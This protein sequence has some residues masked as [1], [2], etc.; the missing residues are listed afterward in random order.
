MHERAPYAES[1]WDVLQWLRSTARSL[2]V[3]RAIY[4]SSSLI[5]RIVIL[6]MQKIPKSVTVQSDGRQLVTS[7][8]PVDPISVA[9][10]APT[11]AV[12]IRKPDL[13]FSADWA[14]QFEL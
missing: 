12:V 10:S 1:D 9:G 4:S 8:G 2:P 14:L 13:P 3:G 7:Y 11:S 6:G 5:E